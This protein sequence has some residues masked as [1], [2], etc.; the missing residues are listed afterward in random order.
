MKIFLD[1]AEIEE[2]R[3]AARWGVLDGVTT[4]PS[5]YAKVGGSYEEILQEICRI[6]SGPVSAEVVAEDVEGMLREGRV[7][8]KLAPNIVVKVPMSEEGLEAISRFADEGI[9]TNCTLI[10][11][12]NQGLLAAKAGASLI[13]PFV[14][15]LDDIN[16]DGMIVIRELAEIFAIHEIEAEILAASMRHPL[17]VTQ[18]AL[19]GAHIATLPFKVLQQMVRHPLTDKGIVQFRT[20]WEKARASTAKGGQQT[21]Q[22]VATAGSTPG[23]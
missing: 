8:A 15:R 6:T 17:H 19:A 16:Q 5:L 12:A 3:T 7:F 11:T 14:G 10:F 22:G 4:N 18:S 1:T 21:K 9:K 23:S 20:D 13:S 2:I